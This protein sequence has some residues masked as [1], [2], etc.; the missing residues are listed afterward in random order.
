MEEEESCSYKSPR[1]RNKTETFDD[2]DSFFVSRTPGNTSSG[3]ANT[4][5]ILENQIKRKLFQPSRLLNSI[6][7]DDPSMLELELAARSRMTELLC[8][9]KVVE[10]GEFK[11]L[12]KQLKF[13]NVRNFIY[14]VSRGKNGMLSLKPRHLT[15]RT[16]VA[17]DDYGKL[18]F[19][20][21]A[22]L[23]LFLTS[24]EKHSIFHF[25]FDGSADLFNVSHPSN[26]KLRAFT[27]EKTLKSGNSSVFALIFPQRKDFLTS[28]ISSGRKNRKKDKS[29][30]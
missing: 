12:N 4:F 17:V 7:E 25:C 15:P 29:L 26:N 30:I 23:L 20:Y 28:H 13:D 6:S 27:A 11:S 16:D 3:Y 18:T 9:T 5:R 2:C 10:S 24:G 21:Y 19:F 14:H 8:D 1:K 22:D